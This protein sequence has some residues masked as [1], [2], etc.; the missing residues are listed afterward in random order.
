VS[1][2]SKVTSK[3]SSSKDLNNLSRIDLVSV[4]HNSEKSSEQIET[5]A[6]MIKPNL[7]QNTRM[8]KEE[9]IVRSSNLVSKESIEFHYSKTTHSLNEKS[10]NQLFQYER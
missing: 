7:G 1:K 3:L 6:K 9:D 10:V 2:N 8:F 4:E 5:L